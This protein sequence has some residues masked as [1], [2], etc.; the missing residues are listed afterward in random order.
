MVPKG[1]MDMHTNVIGGFKIQEPA[2]DLAIAVALASSSMERNVPP[3]VAFIGE[4]GMAQ[5]AHTCS[6]SLSQ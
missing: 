6:A 1:R 5:Q 2:A 4:L 3:D